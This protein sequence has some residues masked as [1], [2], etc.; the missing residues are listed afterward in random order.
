MASSS[1]R[2]W[3]RPWGDADLDDL[4]G[5]A[6]FDDDDIGDVPNRPPTKTEAE[7]Q[8]VDLLVERYQRGTITAKD[9][10]IFAYWSSQAGATGFV[11]QI[12][13]EGAEQKYQTERTS[14]ADAM[15]R[16]ERE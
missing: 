2:S 15:A 5:S 11:E 12:A 10:C 1:T 3:D 4:F 16:R 6:G 9:A 8:L 7:G 14:N 13:K